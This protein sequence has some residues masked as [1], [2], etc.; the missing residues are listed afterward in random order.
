MELNSLSAKTTTIVFAESEVKEP[1]RRVEKSE[2]NETTLAG[3]SSAAAAARRRD[4]REIKRYQL[5]G[6]IQATIA[7]SILLA[8]LVIVWWRS[9]PSSELK[10]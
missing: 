8:L 10:I 7:V 1:N 6:I 5:I 9:V 3:A 4:G 2:I